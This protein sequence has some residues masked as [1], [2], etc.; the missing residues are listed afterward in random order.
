LALSKNKYKKTVK[1]GK[2]HVVKTDAERDN[3]NLNLRTAQGMGSTTDIPSPLEGTTVG[4]IPTDY[5]ETSKQEGVRARLTP[6][7]DYAPSGAVELIKK[8]VIVLGVIATIAAA[9]GIYFKMDFKLSEHTDK[10]QELQKKVDVINSE[11]KDNRERLVKVETKEEALSEELK[12]SKA[13]NE[14]LRDELEKLKRQLPENI[15]KK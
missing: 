14:K 15:E 11:L 1:S 7:R 12:E 3:Y 10:I 5:T 6:P 2:S 9:A 4:Q 13:A 8:V